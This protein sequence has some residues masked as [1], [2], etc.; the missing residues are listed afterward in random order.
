[1]GNQATIVRVPVNGEVMFGGVAQIE[2]EWG[3]WSKKMSHIHEEGSLADVPRSAAE[4]AVAQWETVDLG[5]ARLDRRALQVGEAIAEHPDWSLPR[6][7]GDAA[8]LDGAYRLF[9]HPGVTL[10]ALSMPH[11]TKTRRAAGEQEEMLFI[12]D[13]TELDYTHHPTKQG[14]GP[15]GDGRGRGLLL[16]STLAVVPSSTPQILGLAHQQ[17]V[18]RRSTDGPKPKY[19]TSPESQVWATAAAAVGA[20]PKGV[21]WV[22]VGDRASDDFSF[23]AACR[24]N[25]KDFLVR[26]QHNRLLDWEE[27]EVA[28]EKRKL[29]DFVRSLPAR[30]EYTLEVPARRGRSARTAKMRLTWTEVTVPAP[31]QAPPEVRHQAPMTTWV[32]R[33]WEVDAPSGVKPI[34]WILNT[35]VPTRTLA[36]ALE[37]VEWYTHRW[38]SEDYHQCLK[39]GTAVEERQFDHGDDIRRLLGFL[40]PTA[41]RLLQLRNLARRIPQAPL[42]ANI[43]PLMVRLLQQKLQRPPTESMTADDFW[44][45]VA[46]LGGY[47][48]RS[49]DGPPGWRTLWR[50]WL[51]LHDLTTGARLLAEML[52]N[53]PSCD[54]PSEADPTRFDEQFY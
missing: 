48:G 26:V 17:V 7:M 25:D 20:P 5:D 30:H 10:D 28:P 16:H 3:G 13:T 12:Q 15:I 46:Q 22:H 37:R 43:D 19:A 33:A 9:N 24:D 31:K 1:M 44:R 8:D 21:R 34:E 53:E 29:M 47:L 39:T 27:E 4:W 51:Y 35:S 11:W 50:G 14:L 38:L 2:F 6:Q 41:V 23:M 54:G 40:G 36:D 52:S 42:P 18:L 49:G 32:I 45:G